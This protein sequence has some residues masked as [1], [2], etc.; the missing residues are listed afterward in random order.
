VRFSFERLVDL[1]GM[2]GLSLPAPDAQPTSERKVI[3]DTWIVPYQQNPQ[4]TG[5]TAFL[6]KL[7][8]TMFA[9]TPNNTIIGMGG[10]GKTQCAL[11]YAYSNGAPYDRVLDHGRRSSFS[12]IWL[13]ENW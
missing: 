10:V 11:E 6:Q 1:A 3:E 9:Q 13:R 7:K 2:A 4:F 12:P 8:L 5:W